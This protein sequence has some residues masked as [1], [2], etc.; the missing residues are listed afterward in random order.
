MGVEQRVTCDMCGEVISDLGEDRGPEYVL[1]FSKNIL[2][3][4]EDSEIDLYEHLCE[5][6]ASK[7]EDKLNELD[8]RV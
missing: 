6:C 8:W 1:S 5:D 7:V 2:L 4:D 3:E